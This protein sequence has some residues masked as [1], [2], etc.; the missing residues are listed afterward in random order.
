VAYYDTYLGPDAAF[1]A[2]AWG[3]NPNLPSGNILI[4]DIQSGLWV[5]GALTQP[6]N[7][8][9]VPNETEFNTCAGDSI[10]FELTIGNDFAG[11]G[12]TLDMP[13]LPAGANVVYSS[14]PAMPGS[15]VTVTITDY[16]STLG[17]IDEMTI[18]AS[19]DVNTSSAS[20]FLAVS[21]QPEAPAL[22][23]PAGN[24]LEVA[25]QPAFVWGPASDAATYKLEISTDATSFDDNIVYNASTT[26]ITFTPTVAL[27]EGTVYFWRVKARNDCFSNDSAVRTFTTE[28]VNATGELPGNQLAVYPNPTNGLIFVEFEQPLLE[29]FQVQLVSLT[30]QILQHQEMSAG[31]NG[32][33]L[34]TAAIP[35]GIYLLKLSSAE[36]TLVRKIVVQ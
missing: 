2:G 7:L 14:N 28:G 18:T 35:A 29:A 5:F 34:N 9:I 26:N 30:G 23:V 12:A 25:L 11:T 33:S 19:D 8:S 27:A 6:Q 20:V 17:S 15:T 16:P 24:A 22:S 36:N 31:A 10:S 21:G 3:V 4:S 32:I 13:G 1:Y